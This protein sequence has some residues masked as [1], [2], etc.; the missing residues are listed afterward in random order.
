[1]TDNT[2]G[3]TLTNQPIVIDNGSGV[4]KAGFAGDEKPRLVF[5]NIVGKP[6][7]KRIMVGS[8]LPSGVD[9]EYFIGNKAEE[10][11]GLL[12]LSYPITH[13]IVTDWLAMERVWQHTFSELHSNSEDHPILLTEPPLNP[14]PIRLRSA[15]IFF[16]SLNVPALYLSLQAVLSLYASGR[17]TGAVVDVGDG[18]TQTVPVYD[19][20][21]INSGI[22]RL[23]IGGRDM[24]EQFIKLIRKGVSGYQL[25]TSA[26][27]EIARQMK[28]KLGYI[29]L[30]PSK[31]EEKLEK[32]NRENKVGYKLPDGTII[33][34]GN[35]RWKCGE[36]VF[37]PE[38]IGEEGGGVGDLVVSSIFKA[39]VDLRRVLYGN[40]VLS[41][42]GTKMVG[43]GNRLLE[44]VKKNS[45][46]P[47]DVKLKI[48]A[49]PERLYS[50]WF[51]GSILA[52]LATFTK[53]WISAKDWEEEGQLAV[54]KKSFA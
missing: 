35:E 39:D 48:S 53:M 26:E 25:K 17:T 31:E 32:E 19:G 37:D 43:F 14:L 27:K 9:G 4:I 33:E 2:E 3:I 29:A 6:K 23:D 44:E 15:E 16:E 24:T 54:L 50:N 12:K 38:T 5:Q 8:S 13:G 40:I 30:D 1:M 51:G 49:P 18:V 42:G 10:Y 46:A 52:S 22:Q 34:V 7:H 36:C 21:C 28:E 45:L 20:F 11:R 47:R 41:G